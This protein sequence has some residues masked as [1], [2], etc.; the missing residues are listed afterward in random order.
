[1]NKEATYIFI[2]LTACTR[3]VG[4]TGTH[5]DKHYVSW[6]WADQIIMQMSEMCDDI[7][8][9]LGH[10]TATFG[11]CARIISSGSSGTYESTKLQ[12]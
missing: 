4:S 11:A 12:I 1:M 9:G 8:T 10:K 5:H 2:P 6:A 3:T 7:K